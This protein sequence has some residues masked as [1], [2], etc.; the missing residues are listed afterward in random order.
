MYPESAAAARR[1]VPPAVVS[2][3]QPAEFREESSLAADPAAGKRQAARP[4]AGRSRP[5]EFRAALPQAGALDAGM[6]RAAAMTAGLPPV[7]AVQRARRAE[8]AA[9]RGQPGVAPVEVAVR[10]E[11]QEAVVRVA[12]AALQRAAGQAAVPA[13]PQPVSVGCLSA[14]MPRRLSQPSL[15]G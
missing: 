13:S 14:P 15:R 8:A 5:A 4:K 2:Q 1:A 7:A 3:S 12:A 9:R 10:C 11:R 6:L